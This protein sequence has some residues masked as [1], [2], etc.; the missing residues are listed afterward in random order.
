[1]K[2]WYLGCCILFIHFLSIGQESLEPILF[3][4][5]GKP[6]QQLKTTNSIDSMFVYNYD[7][8]HLPIFDDFSKSKFQAHDAIPGASNVSEQLFYK[9]VD[10]SNVP[11]AAQSIYTSAVTKRKIT[12]NGGTT[13]VP[14]VPI[15]IQVANFSAYPVQYSQ[16]QAYPP[17]YIYDTLDFVNEP[18]TVYVPAPE[19][20]QDSARIFT[21]VVSDQQAIWIDNYAY[22]NYTH[23]KNPW[24][25]GVVTFDGLDETGYPYNFGTTSVGSADR[26]TSKTIDMSGLMPNDSIYMSFLVQAEGLGDE[27]EAADSIVLEF[28]NSALASWDL[29]WS[30]TGSNV[31]DFKVGHVRIT[32]PAFL[33]NGFK[34]RFKNYGGLSGMLDEFHLDYV[35]LRS[36]SGY[37]DTLFKDFAFV[38][39]IGSL[40]DTYT[41]VPWDH[42]VNDPTHMSN[43]VAVSVRNGSNITENNLDGSVSVQFAGNVE[44]NFTLIG[45]TLSGNLPNYAPRTVYSSLHD[46]SAGYSFSTSPVTDSKSFDIIGA[47][48]AQFPNLAQN[49]SSYTVQYFGNE[50]AYDDGSAE[51]AYGITGAQA[52]LAY[53]FDPYEADTLLG[54]Q[55]HFVPSV[56]DVSDKLFLLTVWSDNGG[57]PGT[58]LYED[59]FFYPRTPIYETGRGGFTDYYLVDTG[60]SLPNELFYVGFRQIDADRLNVGFDRNNDN[61]VHTFYSING[62]SVWNTS[63]LAGSAMIRP[64]FATTNNADLSVQTPQEALNWNLYPNPA[65]EV[66]HIQWDENQLFPGAVLTDAQGRWLLEVTSEQREFNL[67]NLPEG[68]YFLQLKGN[69][70][71]VKKILH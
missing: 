29:V 16:V 47:V 17:Y 33:T 31:S 8:L 58:V 62:G 34:F 12:Q 55:I 18:D 21:A 35:H 41:Q 30:M 53:Q 6:H 20:L 42:W 3:Q 7:T 11:L 67:T 68:V 40:I 57:V 1:M 22:H 19:Y 26:L 9:L 52:R 28:Y 38:Y 70:S 54:V 71:A 65:D 49:D 46:F 43:N 61:S 37:Q 2:N 36:G 56:N 66:A 64:I 5:R 50:Y 14:L 63:S 23:A 4:Y 10:L 51:A 13:E 60:L 24:S 69:T 59:A 25:L 32:N 15:T 45:Q 39:P 27:P 48:S 44:G